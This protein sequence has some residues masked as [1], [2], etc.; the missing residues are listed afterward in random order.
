MDPV[1]GF[2]R[3]SLLALAVAVALGVVV[4]TVATVVETSADDCPAA[5]YGCAGF[6]PGEPLQI[7]AVVSSGQGDLGLSATV[8]AT[9]LGR[10]VRVLTFE[11][12]CSVEEAARA[13]RD[14]ATDPPDGPP[15]LAAVSATCP[16]A[17]IPVAQILDDSG[18]ALVVAGE[19]PPVPAPVGFTLVGAEPPGAASLILEVAGRLA[20]LDSGAILVPRTPLRDG[21]VEA[22]LDRL[23][24]E[25]P[26]L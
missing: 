11:V 5:A 14:I 4:S 25:R 1:T 21:L 7:A 12:G 2:S 20:F 10:P 18:I 6:E 26:L 23:D 19:P 3:R 16:A 13:A 15:F 8:P 9:V 24:P 22:G 17:G